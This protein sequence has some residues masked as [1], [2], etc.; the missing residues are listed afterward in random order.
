MLCMRFAHVYFFVRRHTKHFELTFLAHLTDI[1]SSVTASLVYINHSYGCRF[2][3][4][5]SRLKET[6][7]NAKWFTVYQSKLPIE[8]FNSLFFLSLHKLQKIRYLNNITRN[9]YVA[10]MYK[11]IF[12]GGTLFWG[13][14]ELSLIASVF[15]S[16]VCFCLSNCYLFFQIIW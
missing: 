11:L 13:K 3:Q 1:H 6:N 2:L 10:F 9:F 15:F 8:N 12:S 14:N 7:M 16:F 5:R 4:C